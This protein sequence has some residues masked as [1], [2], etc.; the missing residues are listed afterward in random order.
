LPF[1]S[2]INFDKRLIT[3]C[4]PY[5]NQGKPYNNGLI[6]LD[7]D[8]LSTFGTDAAPAWDG[9]WG[10]F[11][12]DALRG[13][14]VLRLVQGEFMGE[15]RAFAFA[16]DPTS[17]ALRLLEI[18]KAPV[19][20]DSDG[21]IT[22]YH[23]SRSIDFDQPFNE[24]YIYGADYWIDTVLEDTTFTTT[25]RPDKYPEFQP[26]YSFSTSPIH[27]IPE[28]DALVDQPGFYPRRSLPKP[29]ATGDALA[30]KRIFTRGYEFQVATE[31][32]GRASITQFRMHDQ[33]E[34]EN[35]KAKV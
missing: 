24:K 34:I 15:Q 6:A 16:L 13:L 5:E 25:F 30:T 31:W 27:N 18:N 33:T 32:T 11:N 10:A 29:A 20:S 28:G 12:R 21:P 3:T 22:A 23:V 14:R 7:F 35:S 26:W 8:V 1:T 9:H 2:A 4:T 19:G 17:G